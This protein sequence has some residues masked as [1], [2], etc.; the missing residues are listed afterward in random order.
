MPYTLNL[1]TGRFDY[2]RKVFDE[3]ITAPSNPYQG[4]VYTNAIDNNVYIFFGGSWQV[5]HTLVSTDLL[6]ETGDLLLLERGN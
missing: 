5:L 4:Q 1:Y 3:F 6:T 2:Y